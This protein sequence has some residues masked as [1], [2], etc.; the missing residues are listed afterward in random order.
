MRKNET[1]E[2]I[3]ALMQFETDLGKYLELYDTILPIATRVT[4][5]ENDKEGAAPKRVK[6]TPSD[7]DD[8]YTTPV[9]NAIADTVV[10]AIDID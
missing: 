7:T 2:R 8:P 6:R 5:D 9:L 4:K 10:A 1:V 3:R